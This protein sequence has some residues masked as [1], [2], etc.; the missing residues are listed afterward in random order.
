VAHANLGHW[1]PAARSMARCAELGAKVFGAE[2]VLVGQCRAGHAEVLLELGRHRDALAIIEDVIATHDVTKFRKENQALVHELHGRALVGV[3]KKQDGRAALE[4]AL[5]AYR[6]IGST[7]VAV[8]EAQL[9][10]LR[11]R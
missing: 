8:V 2:H 3:G 5:E 9:R 7:R 10:A 6:A 4:R 11:G 1:E